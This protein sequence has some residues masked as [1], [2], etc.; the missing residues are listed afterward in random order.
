[1]PTRRSGSLHRMVDRVFSREVRQWLGDYAESMAAI[2]YVQSQDSHIF[3]NIS[4]N[5]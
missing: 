4:N 1:M 3:K 5:L 2:E